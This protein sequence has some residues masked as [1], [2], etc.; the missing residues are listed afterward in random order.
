MP[1][2][3]Y[4]GELELIVLSAVSLL[5]DDAYGV[6]IRQ[7]IDRRTGRD[8][9]MGV[10]YSA[11]ARLEQKGY[12]SFTLSEPLPVRGGRARKYV[13]LTPAGAR[14]LRSSTEALA[15]MLNLRLRTTS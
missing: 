15:N 2:G 4:L 5:G 9:P 13:R 14:T 3:E 1:K 11:L 7:E 6:T 10:I 8:A 12:V